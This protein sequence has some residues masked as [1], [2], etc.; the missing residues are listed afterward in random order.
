[1]KKQG[2][3]GVCVA[4]V[5]VQPVLAHH[6]V[7]G[8]GAA[9]LQGPGAPI[10]SA[11]SA[12]LPAGAVLAYLKVDEARFKKYDWAAPNAD[13][14]R[15]SMLGLGY[16]VTPWFSAYLSSCRTMPRSRSPAVSIRAAGR[17]PR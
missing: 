17:T 16:G 12:V 7:A 4:F 5:M 3:V 10:E 8:V 1:M 13:Y 14:A 6:G 11:S 9:A 2:L 15:F